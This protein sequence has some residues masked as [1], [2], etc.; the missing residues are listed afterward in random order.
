M[1][2][3]YTDAYGAVDGS[4]HTQGALSCDD[5][6][7]LSVADREHGGSND[8]DSAA[9]QAGIS[10]QPRVA[11]SKEFPD[12]PTV[13]AR[14]A[15]EAHE[16]YSIG[17][18]MAAIL[19]ARTVVEATA[20]ERGITSGQL[21]KKI[22]AMKDAELIRKST[23]EAAHEIRHFGNDMAHGDLDDVPDTDDAAEVL[24]LMDE[25]L[26]EVYQGPARTERVKSRRSRT[27][28]DEKNNNSVV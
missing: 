16:A 10:W 23:A 28:P 26:N 25:V 24:T 7:R 2:K 11:V 6:S 18:L 21:V 17:A 13:I 27:E 9:H 5:C 19:M 4:T 12:V 3:R 22:D 8:I 1:T 15:K 14:A 20:K